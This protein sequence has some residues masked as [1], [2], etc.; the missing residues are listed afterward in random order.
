MASMSDKVFRQTTKQA[1]GAPKAQPAAPVDPLATVAMSQGEVEA[2]AKPPVEPKSEENP[3]VP[4]APP[5]ADVAYRVRV[6][7][8]GKVMIGSCMHTFKADS[9]LDANHYS[10]REFEHLLRVL[11]T[12]RIK[13]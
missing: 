4:S 3:P 11:K 13:D 12:E 9:V 6:L 1:D 10:T 8:E 7:Q 5:V 2:R